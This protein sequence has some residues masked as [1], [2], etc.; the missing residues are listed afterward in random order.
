MKQVLNYLLFLSRDLRVRVMCTTVTSITYLHN[1][2]I[3]NSRIEYIII[4][5]YAYY[6]I[7]LVMKKHTHARHS[8]IILVYY[9]EYNISTV[10][11]ILHGSRY[12]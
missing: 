3:E 2:L 7:H 11:I 6:N 1:N 9:D 4:N 12:P 8:V 5:K 10:I